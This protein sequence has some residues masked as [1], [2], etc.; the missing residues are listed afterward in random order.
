MKRA[1]AIRDGYEGN[2]RTR[3]HRAVKL[4]ECVSVTA[5]RFELYKRLSVSTVVELFMCRQIADN[6][7]TAW[8]RVRARKDA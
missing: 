3:K 6:G 1:H 4:N 8:E 7:P 2:N 5:E